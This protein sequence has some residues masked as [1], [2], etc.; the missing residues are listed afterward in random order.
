MARYNIIVLSKPVAG[1]ETE[2]DEWYTNVHVRDLLK[3][4]GFRTAQRFRIMEG[5][6]S[7]APQQFIAMYEVETD[8]LAATMA[9]VQQRLGTDQMPMSEAFDMSTAAFLVAEPMIE[10]LTAA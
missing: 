6:S 10:K 2:F 9:I 8:D 5:L 7:G 3:V 4:P 1:R